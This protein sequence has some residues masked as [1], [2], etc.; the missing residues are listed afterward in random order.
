MTR[1]LYRVSPWRSLATSRRI[2]ASCCVMLAVVA[3]GPGVGAQQETLQIDGL[4]AP[5]EIVTDHWGIAHIYAENEHDLFFVQ[6]YSAVRDRLFQFEIWRRQATGTVAEILGEREL[7]RDIGAR[8]HQFRGDMT[9][10]MRHY[11][12]RGD[13]IIPAFVDGINAY[14][15]ETERRPELLPIEFALLDL[16]PGRWTPEV[17][18]SRHNGLV[19]NVT[20]EIDNAQAV[21]L[22]GTDAVKELNYYFGDPN[23][24]IDP[25]LDVSLLSDDILTLYRAHRRAVRFETEDIVAAHRGDEA[26]FERLAAALPSELDMR[27]EDDEAI[28][29]NNW[30]VAGSKTL[31]GFPMMANDPHRT[32][33]AP[34]LRYWVHLVAPGWNVIG[35]GEPILPGVSIGQNE[36]GAWGLTIFGQDNE[37]LLVYDT[38]PANPNQYRYLGEWE[39]M[40]VIEESIPVKGRGEVSVEL[41]YTRHGPVLHEDTGHHTAYALAAAWLDYGSAPYLASLRMNQATTWEEFREACSYSRIPSENMVW[42]DRD[43]NIGY[44]AVGVSPIRPNHSGLVPVPGDGRYEWDGYLPI[45]ALPHVL[46]PEQGFYGTANNYTVPDGYPYWEALHY[47]WGD[48]MRAARVNEVLEA[49]R[50]LTVV[51]M[52]RL[53]MDELSVAARNI[54]PLLRNLE[55]G[56]G[57]A[58]TTRRMLLD[59]DYVLD[60]SS[61]EA[62]IYVSWER[63]LRENIK[64]AMVPPE[65]VHLFRG[66]N[67]KRM[68]DWLAAPDGRF[69]NDPIAGR[70]ALLRASL[71][72]A[73]NGLHER[74]G[75]SDMTTWRYGGEKFKHALIRHPIGAAVNADLRRR[76]DVGPFPRGGYGGTV[77]NT[78]SGDNQTS[79][80]SFMI[81]ADTE[82][83]DHSIGLNAPGQ[84]GDPKALFMT[85]WCPD[86]RSV[87]SNCGIPRG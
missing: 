45:K 1:G 28:G 58:D 36:N 39:D 71:A 42:A 9:T 77:H 65:A 26:T 4:I 84:S 79:G 82:N 86:S 57:V 76:L 34:S 63:R 29:S 67:T 16:T 81:I 72:E 19:G 74:F 22:L 17:V 18:I 43:G 54:V 66:I 70:D 13:T 37:D 48:Q 41:K 68:I 8:L 31:T 80:A 30:V 12:P 20:R 23:L 15:A 64:I 47:T 7:E 87:E 83:W 25:M 69:G 73:L 75:T 49:G 24:T 11:H 60:K 53:Q 40:T 85:V 55:A 62:A 46:N 32:Q 2:V 21:A 38:N 6:G 10:E 56:E 61:V 52:M 14:I 78:G 51:D 59:W 27:Y 3:V 50:H 5:V 44:Q 35:G 33:A